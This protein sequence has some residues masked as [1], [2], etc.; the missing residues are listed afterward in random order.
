MSNLSPSEPTPLLLSLDKNPTAVSAKLS[1]DL[2]ELA[3]A[4][5]LAPRTQAAAGLKIATADYWQAGGGSLAVEATAVASAERLLAQLQSLGLEQGAHW[6][7]VVSGLLPMAALAQVAELENLGFL[8]PVYRPVTNALQ[9]N[10]KTIGAET[11]AGSAV[12]QGD[13]AQRSNLA[14]SQ[15]GVNGAGITVGILSDSY[16]NL[17]GEA[18]D[19]ASGDLPAGVIVLDDL[20]SGGSDEGRAMLQIVYDVA[21]GAT[22][23]FATA[24]TGQANFA[25]NIINLAKP[26]AQGGAGA[27]VIV[28]DIIYF[29]EPFFQDG[30]IAQAVDQVAA[31]GVAYFSSAGNN[32]DASYESV[33]VPGLTQGNYTFHDFN[34]GAGV[35]IYQNI[36]LNNGEF[37]PVF[38]WDQPFASAGGAGAQSD[39]DIFIFLDNNNDGNP[40]TLLTSSADSNLGADAFEFVSVSGTGTAFFAIGKFNSAGGPDPGLIK[41]VDFGFN[42]TVEFATN[43]STSYGHSQAAGGQGVGAAF[44]RNTPAFGVNPPQPESFTSLGGAPI[45]FDVQGNRL[46]VPEIRNQ[47]AITAPDGVDTTF[48]GSDVEGNGRPNFFGT[49]ASAP[50]AAGAAALLRQ[51]VPSATNQEIYAALQNTALDMNAPGYDFLTGAGLIQV[52]AAL[53]ALVG[54]EDLPEI[55]VVA[56][57][58][59]AA[60]TLAG[61]TLNRGQFRFTRTGD[62]SSPLTVNFTL[63]GEATNGVDH[64]TFNLFVTFNAGQSSRNLNL[65]PIDDALTEGTETRSL[66]L[67][68]GANYSIGGNASAEIQILDNDTVALPVITV[69]ATDAAAAETLA[70]QTAN[71][72][73]FRFT[74]AGDTSSPLTV[75]FSIDGT[76]TNGVDFNPLPASVTFNAGQSSRTLGVIIKDD[77]LA[78]GTET[79]ILSLESGAGYSVGAPS[80]ASVD[81]LDNETAALPSVN[82]TAN[83]SGVSEDGG[84]SLIYTVTRSGSTAN[85]LTVNFSLGG[86]AENGSDYVLSGAGAGQITFASGQSS[87]LLVLDPL[88]DGVK[89]ANETIELTLLPGAGYELGSS[90]SATTTILNDDGVF[91]QKGTPGDDV[92]EAGAT[93]ILTGRAGQDILIG[94]AGPD[95]LI[96]GPGADTLT[97]GANF[98]TFSFNTPGEG[99][100]T[101]TDFNPLEDLIQ[102]SAAGFGAGLTPGETL[103]PEQFSLGAL[104]PA[105]RFIFDGTTGQLGFDPDGSGAVS[106]QSFAALSPGLNLTEENILVV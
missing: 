65:T 102:V 17:G 68:P 39:L 106:P 54:E 92:M 81:I 82:L 30:I 87:V 5:P 56:S 11:N 55:N 8:R 49:S 69:A 20:P 77:A 27:E 19:I 46:A 72:G 14:R 4:S 60:E 93:R 25:Q 57:D 21:P 6:G 23:A 90:S 43:S 52:D 79:V 84:T 62:T 63:G 78:E 58:A 80:I 91:N 41:Y 12:S 105:T 99:V 86:G 100:D 9:V 73:Q 32:A 85:P 96:G 10:P 101:L 44:Y 104:T 24:F 83:W 51:A 64:N 50:S 40:E 67:S 89:E 29:S 97:G 26:L 66:T 94:G 36:V 3:V 75:N 31:A 71:R 18:A 15:F 38:Q 35:D 33:F 70:G 45:L 48:F 88:T 47:P 42:N 16:N 34:P 2:W 74:R 103:A 98:D 37:S 22:L 76:A 61:Q 95:S 59:T 1:S 13:I 28:D 7:K 53:A